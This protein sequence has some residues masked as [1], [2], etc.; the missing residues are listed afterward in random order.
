M[1]S[2]LGIA[3]LNFEN[4]VMDGQGHLPGAK[5]NKKGTTYM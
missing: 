4:W 3:G 2:Q 1:N 5:K